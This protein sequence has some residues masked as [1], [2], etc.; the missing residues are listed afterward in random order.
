MWLCCQTPISPDAK[1]YCK[2]KKVTTIVKLHVKQVNSEVKVLI[3]IKMIILP[4]YLL[5]DL[6][7]HTSIKENKVLN[8]IEYID[9]IGF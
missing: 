3:F 4:I 5:C 7:V 1:L 6:Q 9:M 2:S 8:F